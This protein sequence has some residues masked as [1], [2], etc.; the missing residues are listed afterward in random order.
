MHIL[1]KTVS[2]LLAGVILASTSTSFA[3]T[4]KESVIS[5]IDTLNTSIATSIAGKEKTLSDRA[6][7]LG[8]RYDS[9]I[10]S[11]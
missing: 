9:T 6:N 1:Q 2:G 8:N 5:S 10:K 4:N 11:L 3:L 7:E